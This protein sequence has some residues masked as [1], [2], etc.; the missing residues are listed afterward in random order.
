[1]FKTYYSDPGKPA[2]S[3]QVSS[4]FAGIVEEISYVVH[5]L[6]PGVYDAEWQ[7]IPRDVYFSSPDDLEACRTY[8]KLVLKLGT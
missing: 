3:M 8:V 7:T 2:F 1:M 6:E 4:N 5:S